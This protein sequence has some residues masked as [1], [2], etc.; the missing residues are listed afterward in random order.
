MAG[1]SGPADSDAG[2][3]RR[4]HDG[5]VGGDLEARA[6]FGQEL[7]LDQRI[8][9]RRERP[10]ESEIQLRRVCERPMIEVARRGVRPSERFDGNLDG[11]ADAAD[12]CRR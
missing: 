3:A 12:L 10:V 5:S 11:V 9:S 7:R 8:L 1:L 2:T 6:G 4:G